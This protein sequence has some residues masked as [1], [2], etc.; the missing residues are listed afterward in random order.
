MNNAHPKNS[1]VP[2]TQSACEHFTAGEAA[3]FQQVRQL[4][5]GFASEVVKCLPLPSFMCYNNEACTEGEHV[6]QTLW[7]AQEAARFHSFVFICV[8]CVFPK[9]CA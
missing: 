1:G 3:N 4:S 2:H 5:L 9:T 6:S 8:Q 7:S